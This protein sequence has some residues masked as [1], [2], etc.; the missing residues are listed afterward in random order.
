MNYVDGTVCNETNSLYYIWLIVLVFYVLD[1]FV[2]FI[3]LYRHY[4]YI[5]LKKLNI[6]DSNDW[7]V[8]SLQHI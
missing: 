7:I 3:K 1:G 4:P 6:Y 5:C 2:F 8:Y